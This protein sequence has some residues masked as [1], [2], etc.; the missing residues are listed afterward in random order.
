M[1]H[2]WDA[3]G[4]RAAAGESRVDRESSRQPADVDAR[5]E[6]FGGDEVGIRA[7]VASRGHEDRC[8]LA[9]H[10]EDLERCRR[11]PLDVYVRGE[12]DSREIDEFHPAWYPVRRVANPY[13]ASFILWR[14]LVFHALIWGNGYLWIDRNGRGDPIGLYNL[15]PDR[16]GPEVVKGE[17]L[18]VT[19]TTKPKSGALVANVGRPERVP[20]RASGDGPLGR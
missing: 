19:E 3:D 12:N 9:G 10:H 18:Y 15:L 6:L 17:L 14:R 4:E 20:R 16:T 7:G 13:T 1:N 5:N 2:V 11:M 8:R